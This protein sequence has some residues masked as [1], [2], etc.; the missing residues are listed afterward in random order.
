MRTHRQS[1]LLVTMIFALTGTPALSNGGGGGGGD[2]MSSQSPSESAPLYD[3]VVEY[4]K[5]VAAYEAKDF[6]TA[7]TALKHVVQT[8][9]RHA[10]AQYLLGSSLLQL[11]D[12][13]GARK[14]LEAAVKVDDK[15][16]DAHRDLGIAYAKLGDAAK[17]GAQR[18]AL[19][20]M[21][22]SCAATCSDAPQL[23]AA[24]QAVEAALAGS[25]Q[26]SLSPSRIAP[27][28][29]VDAVYVA[30]VGLINEGRYQPAIDMLQGALVSAGPHPDLLT[31]LGFANRKMKRYEEARYW[32]E[33]A[34]AV[35]P[36]HR[37][38]IE[39]YGELKLEM[40]DVTG[41]RQHLARLD[42]MCRF[43]CQQADELRAMMRRAGLSVS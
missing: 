1:R 36:D 26:A 16:I 43:G 10:P 12:A 42:T 7:T 14:P 3:P 15:M 32:Y 40:G 4:K 37:G 22:T 18:D 28:S 41:A 19:A 25:P 6:K 2:S 13:K 33:A 38:A 29:N 35:A 17:A 30:A 39:Y 8:A 9:P 21:K 24:I 31:Y 20:S 23:D 27:A 11:G 34:L 5:G